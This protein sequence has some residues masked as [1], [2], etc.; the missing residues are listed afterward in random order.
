MLELILTKYPANKHDAESWGIDWK[1][2]K[3]P[4]VE[5]C[6]PTEAEARAEAER[7]FP[8]HKVAGVRVFE[9]KP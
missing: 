9:R 1:I 3:R 7:R 4:A 8:G 5:R 2:D 6:F